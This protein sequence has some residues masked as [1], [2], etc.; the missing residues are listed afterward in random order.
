VHGNR[1]PDDDSGSSGA[2]EW[3]EDDQATSSEEEYA[4]GEEMQKYVEQHRRFP[5]SQKFPDVTKARQQSQPRKPPTP[6]KPS[7]HSGEVTYVVDPRSRENPHAISQSCQQFGQ[8][9]SG[10][11]ADSDNHTSVMARVKMEKAKKKLA[12]DNSS[13]ASVDSDGGKSRISPMMSAGSSMS[14]PVANRLQQ[15]RPPLSPPGAVGRPTDSR[16]PVPDSPRPP[17][18]RLDF[19]RRSAGK[20]KP[21]DEDSGNESSRVSRWWHSKG[22]RQKK[23][24]TAAG[25]NEG[26]KAQQPKS[27]SGHMSTDA[28]MQDL[29]GYSW[30]IGVNSREQAEKI[31]KR[32]GQNGSFVVRNSQH[33]GPGMPYT[34]T[35]FH[36]GYIFHIQIRSLPDRRGLFAVGTEKVNELRFRSLQHIVTHYTVNP[37]E[38]V[39]CNDDPNGRAISVTLKYKR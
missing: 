34:L 2:E 3:T 33:G 38:L 6:P 25:K 36:Q 7:R 31:V 4:N 16:M 14:L 5:A 39:R 13:Y 19:H 24:A 27:N 35:I 15:Q 23:P 29:Q 1:P 20:S 11:D 30:Y 21:D 22:H 12:I 9:P 26:R 28:A 8:L 18:P 17:S 32:D 37:I 10:G